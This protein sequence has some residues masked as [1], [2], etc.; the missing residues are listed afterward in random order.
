M[1]VRSDINGTVWKIGVSV[2]DEVGADDE[3]VILESMKMEVPVTAPSAGRVREI[4]VAEGDSVTED[5]V[6]VVI[7]PG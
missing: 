5:Q 7:D 6:L 2:G 4:V 1:D 3:L